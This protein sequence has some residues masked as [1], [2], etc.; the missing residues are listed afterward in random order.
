MSLVKVTSIH[1]GRLGSWDFANV[2]LR[3]SPM[4]RIHTDQSAFFYRTKPFFRARCFAATFRGKSLLLYICHIY[5]S[6][7]TLKIP[8]SYYNEPSSSI[9]WL[10]GSQHSQVY[11]HSVIII[12]DDR[13]CTDLKCGQSD[14]RL[15]ND[16]QNVERRRLHLS[17][18]P[19]V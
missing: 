12:I 6:L 3:G 8:M 14:W 5:A 17:N 10:I 4:R 2:L 7:V 9:Q 15:D 13:K 18:G 16:R 1:H 19:I 11:I